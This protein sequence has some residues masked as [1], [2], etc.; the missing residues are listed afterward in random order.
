MSGA[1]LRNHAGLGLTMGQILCP[2]RYYSMFWHHL[3]MLSSQKVASGARDSP[4][5]WGPFGH[6]RAPHRF[7][8]LVATPV[9]R[10]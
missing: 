4:D 6:T 7:I 5:S 10:T 1:G 8:L 3:S 2:R 9:V